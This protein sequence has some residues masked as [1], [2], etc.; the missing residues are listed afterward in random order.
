MKIIGRVNKKF[1]MKAGVKQVVLEIIKVAQVD[2]QVDGDHDWLDL[3]N[4]I[5]GID[6]KLDIYRVINLL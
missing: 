5:A 6:K 2:D 3:V 1:A 4:G